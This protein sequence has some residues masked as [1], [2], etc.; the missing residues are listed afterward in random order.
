[1]SA[2]LEDATSLESNDFF[3]SWK[4][5]SLSF[6]ILERGQRHVVAVV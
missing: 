3:E 6:S 5:G 1:M 2:F 4:D